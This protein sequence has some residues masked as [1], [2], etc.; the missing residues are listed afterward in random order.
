[1]A[2]RTKYWL[3]SS[4]GG[5]ATATATSPHTAT[6]QRIR[7][8]STVARP[9]AVRASSVFFASASSTSAPPRSRREPG[10]VAQYQVEAACA[11]PGNHRH[12]VLAQPAE[13]VVA[14]DTPE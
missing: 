14:L 13:H 2:T 10:H 7:N 8:G 4:D 6:P 5:H 11:G 12:T 1:M 9:R 3:A